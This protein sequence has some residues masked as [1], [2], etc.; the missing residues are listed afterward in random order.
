MFARPG[1]SWAIA[2]RIGPKDLTPYPPSPN[3][4][5]PFLW[6]GAINCGESR[7]HNPRAAG[8]SNL[9]NFGANAPSNFRT[10]HAQ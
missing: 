7:H 8:P 2:L 9:R 6:K 4:D 5:I 1:W 10:F 3:G